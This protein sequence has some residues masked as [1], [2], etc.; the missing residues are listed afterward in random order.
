MLWH[1]YIAPLPDTVNSVW[2]SGMV[3][4]SRD[5]TELPATHM[6]HTAG[7]E[8]HLE[9]YIYKSPTAVT[10]CLLVTTHFS[11][12]ERMVDYVK[13]ESAASGS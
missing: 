8:P 2:R 5:H 11:D 1:I 12:P 10:H 3:R 7:A 4:V 6:F 13:F 9:H